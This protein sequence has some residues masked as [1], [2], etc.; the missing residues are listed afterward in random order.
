MSARVWRF[1]GW[2]LLGLALILLLLNEV[3]GRLSRFHLE[4]QFDELSTVLAHVLR[5]A[6]VH[7]GFTDILG[8]VR[9]GGEVEGERW[10]ALNRLV[11]QH[12][13]DLPVAKVKVYDTDGTTVFSTAKDEVGRNSSTNP[14]VQAGLSG[15]TMSNIV[16]RQEFNSFDRIL[17]N[18]DLHQQY[19]PL[20]DP[21]SGLV[22]G[23][24]EL[25]SDVTEL[26]ADIESTSRSLLFALA[27]VLGLFFLVQFVL[28]LRTD[29]ALVSEQR[30][31]TSYLRDLEHAQS[32]LESRVAERTRE[33]EASRHF[34]QSVI[35]GIASP[36]MVIRPDLRVSMMNQAARSLIPPDASPQSMSFCYQVTHRQNAPCEAPLHPCSFA[37]VL[38]KG[39]T[40]TLRHAHR[41][42][43]NEPII[44]DVISTPLKNTEGDLIGVIEI[45]HDVTELVRIKD[46]LQRSE[47]RLKAIM[48]NVPDAI[49]T[50]DDAGVVNSSNRAAQEIFGIP[51]ERLIG[52]PVNGLLG[53]DDDTVF[54][55]GLRGDGK[56][57][58]REGWAERG[59]TRFPVEFWIGSVDLGGQRR[60][61]AVVRD[62]TRRKRA[63]HE[64]EQTRRQYYHQEKMAAIGQLAAGILH[65]VGNPIAAIAGAAQDLRFGAES[66]CGDEPRCLMSE[67]LNANVG[68]I[69]DQSDRLGKITREIADFASPRPVEKQLLDLNGLIRSTARLVSYDRRFR[70]VRLDLELDRNL[71]AVEGVADQL[72]QVM[73]NLF[74]NAI[75]AVCDESEPR[76]LVST[77]EGGGAV[78]VEVSD[79]GSGMDPRTLKRALEPFFTTKSVGK[80]TG[81]GLSV[82]QSIMSAHKGSIELSSRIGEGTTVRL[83]IPLSDEPSE[84]QPRL[85]ESAA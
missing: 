7:D 32:V 73:M 28:Y 50:Y 9:A 54:E 79:N 38:G 35:D 43:K 48:D 42:P 51:F 8:S 53:K 60:F 75:D 46:G 85:T 1:T 5:N 80:G 76:I 22:I 18:R 30:Q 21:R 81:L 24:F 33:L 63:E 52:R 69:L 34:L 47:A 55:A 66:R 62:I 31:T 44:V 84:M 14:G 41:G 40:V 67:T 27:A 64:L 20:R 23:T 3:Y 13:A 26:L 56:A 82:C 57:E 65:E 2:S 36:V 16:H 72:T 70:G 59:G 6:L 83:R 74:I 17:E 45:Q 49:L 25:Y 19:I 68:L 61:I 77:G 58:T 10:D 15:A 37:E 39:G 11:H 12:V 29:K 4:T 78:E 71:P